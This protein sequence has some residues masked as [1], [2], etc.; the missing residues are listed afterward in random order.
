[1]PE[2]KR[3]LVHWLS[4]PGL[5]IL[6]VLVLWMLL[7]VIINVGHAPA[8]RA[9]CLRNLKQL[10][11]ALAMYAD[12]YNGRLP[13]DA[14]SPTLVGSMRLLSNVVTSAEFLHCPSD[15]RPKA[16]AEANFSKLTIENISYSYVPNL[17][18]Q[19]RPDSIVALDRIDATSA[20]S[21]WPRNGNH[22][23]AGGNVL[24]NEGY[25]LWFNTLPSALKDKDGR[26]IVLS[27]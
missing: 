4:V 26:Q 17:I 22:K 1:M 25:T 3:K 8:R 14:A 18:W 12:H 19:D 7:P 21:T 2:M 5:A 11:L 15:T 20:G 10:S 6:I 9:F 23:G 27:P 16:K 13:M 24:F